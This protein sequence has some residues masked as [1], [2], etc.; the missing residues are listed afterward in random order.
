MT[1][2]WYQSYDKLIRQFWYVSHMLIDNRF[3]IFF[4]KIIKV[5]IFGCTFISFESNK[6]LG[7]QSGSFLLILILISLSVCSI[8]PKSEHNFITHYK[9]NFRYPQY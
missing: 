8:L 3:F 5:A 2:F 4:K 6:S 7:H 9:I 1:Y